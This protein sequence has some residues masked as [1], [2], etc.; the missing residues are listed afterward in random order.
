MGA[1]VFNLSLPAELLVIIDDAAKLNYET[2]SEYIKRAIISRLKEEGVQ[3]TLRPK[4]P[5]ELRREQLKNFLAKYN[6]DEF[7]DDQD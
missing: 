1:K 2:R 6:E 3:G 5:E 4:S 7:T